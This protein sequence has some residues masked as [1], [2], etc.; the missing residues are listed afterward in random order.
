MVTGCP[1]RQGGGDGEIARQ[2]DVESLTDKAAAVS[3]E[4]NVTGPWQV[5]SYACEE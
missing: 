2:R 1:L 3:E 5:P 4:R